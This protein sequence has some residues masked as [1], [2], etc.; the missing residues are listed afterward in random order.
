MQRAVTRTEHG[1]VP[2]LHA[3]HPP[4]IVYV[5]HGRA[6]RLART[7]ASLCREAGF[8]QFQSGLNLACWLPGGTQELR[9]RDGELL[10]VVSGSETGNA[11]AQKQPTHAFR[12]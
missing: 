3:Q 9:R 10:R 5:G 4:T 2:V 1:L 7:R 6:L 8:S 11:N 12:L